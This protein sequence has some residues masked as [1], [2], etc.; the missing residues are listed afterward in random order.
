[1]KSGV[2]KDPLLF[3]LIHDFFKVCLPT[4]R[5][6]SRHTVRSYK[7]AFDG[8]LDFVVG[9]QKIAL[10]EVTF[11][12]IDSS[13]LAAFLDSLESCGC[14]VA[15]RNLR[16]NCIRAFY[17]YAAKI[18]PAAVIHYDEIRKVPVKKSE[19]AAVIEY[20]SEAAVAAILAQPDTATRK[21]L[22]DQ[23][24]LLVF[25]DTGARIAEVL[26]IRLRDIKFGDTPTVTLL[27]K[28]GKTRVVPLS[29]KT[30]GHCRNYLGVYHPGES[31]YSSRHLFYTVRHSRLNPMNDK[32]VRDMMALH[33]T[34]AREA[35][36]DVPLKVHPHLWRH[37]RAMHLYQHGMDLTLVSQWL[38]HAR[39]DSTLVYAHADTEHKRKAIEAAV[40]EDS[41]L[42]SFVNPKRYMVTDDE[43]LKRLYGLR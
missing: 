19:G 36:P 39:L 3:G 30:V 2:V 20:M 38:G 9:R 10:A 34:A 26:N 24:M 13:M 15:T 31:Q 17:A 7:T 27:G 8:L 4:Q 11:E 37:T 14:S 18:E 35:C 23:F 42:K 22:R 5:N 1:M 25:Y 32:T 40:S 12:M 21:G 33:G 41:P 6:S 43:M 29:E 28:G 16:L